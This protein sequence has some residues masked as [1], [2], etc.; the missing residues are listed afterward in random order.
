MG[1]L[2]GV[3]DIS[4]LAPAAQGHALLQVGLL[5]PGEMK[6]SQGQGAGPVADAAEQAAAPAGQYLDQFNRTLAQ[7][8][9][10]RSQAADRD[11][12]CTVYVSIG[13]VK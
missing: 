6:E 2:Q 9:V 10:A 8:A 11:K 5:R 4:Y 13:Q 12:P 7:G 1:H 3:I